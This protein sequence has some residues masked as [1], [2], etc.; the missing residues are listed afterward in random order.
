[1]SW[2]LEM[3]SCCYNCCERIIH[4]VYQH[5]VKGGYHFIYQHLVKGGYHFVYQHLV[6]G[7]YACLEENVNVCGK[8]MTVFSGI[9]SEKMRFRFL[10]RVRKYWWRLS[11][12]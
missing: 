7:G 9:C 2:K 8:K 10:R 5:L 6:K 12:L 4:F 11:V 1:M 3:F